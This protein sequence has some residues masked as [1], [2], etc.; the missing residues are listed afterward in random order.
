METRELNERLARALGFKLANGT[1]N[2]SPVVMEHD[3]RGHLARTYCFTPATDRNHL[4]EYVLPEIERRGLWVEF[5]Q[6]AAETITTPVERIDAVVGKESAKFQ[7][8]DLVHAM[9]VMSAMIV[10]TAPPADLALAALE[11]L[12]GEA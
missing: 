9:T 11:V 2:G 6:R 7:G 8:T 12:E 1:Q 3:A 5:V 10:L 4:A